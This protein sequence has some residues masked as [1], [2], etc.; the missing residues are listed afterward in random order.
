MERT[1]RDLPYRDEILLRAEQHF[2]DNVTAHL[3]C[4]LKICKESSLSIEFEALLK[5]NYFDKIIR[6]SKRISNNFNYQ[7]YLI[8]DIKKKLRDIGIQDDLYHV[9]V[10]NDPNII[11]DD[12]KLDQFCFLTNKKLWLRLSSHMK[13][14]YICE[15]DINNFDN[16]K[17]TEY[18]SEIKNNFTHDPLI[19]MTKEINQQ[20]I[21]NSYNFTLLI[22]KDI[23]D[24]MLNYFE[25]NLDKKYQNFIK[26]FMIEERI[27][28]LKDNFMTKYLVENHNHNSIKYFDGCDLCQ[29]YK[30]HNSPYK[31]IVNNLIKFGINCRFEYE[32]NSLKYVVTKEY[33]ENLKIQFNILNTNLKENLKS[34]FNQFILRLKSNI[35]DFNIIP[36][37]NNFRF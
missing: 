36:Q 27:V 35:N 19:K 33:V 5:Q 22:L 15:I 34:H 16:K 7:N 37:L 8:Y 1:I 17:F 29:F 10:S 13:S 21:I 14:N 18:Y 26:M 31:L 11:F 3:F 30:K 20:N 4:Y 24:D 9:N 6:Y 32:T 12:I 25:N 23:Y 2:I 28:N